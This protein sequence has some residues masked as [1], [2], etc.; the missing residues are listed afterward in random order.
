MWLKATVK[1][2]W[3]ATAFWTRLCGRDWQDDILLDTDGNEIK[4]EHAGQDYA[5]ATPIGGKISSG[6]RYAR[7]SMMKLSD[8]RSRVCWWWSAMAMRI[9]RMP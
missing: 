6:G 1:E 4:I 5:V 9:F 3:K 7:T 2:T 8:V